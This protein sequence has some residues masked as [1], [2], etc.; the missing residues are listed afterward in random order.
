MKKLFLNDVPTLVNKYKYEKKYKLYEY[1][2][3]DNKKNICK[4]KYC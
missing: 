1:N 2:L 3:M 4:K